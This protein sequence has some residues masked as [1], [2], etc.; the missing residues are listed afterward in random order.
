MRKGGVAG[1]YRLAVKS[2][3]GFNVKSV[4]AAITDRWSAEELGIILKYAWGGKVFR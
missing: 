1:T 2:H 3:S 4:N